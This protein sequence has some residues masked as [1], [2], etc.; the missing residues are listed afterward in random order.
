MDL[1]D[2]TYDQFADQYSSMIARQDESACSFY[3]DLVVPRLLDYI[4]DVADLTVLDAG[5][6]EG[7]VSRIL[8]NHG[9]QVVALDISPRLIELAR[10]NNPK[11]VMDYQVHDLSKPLPQYTQFF[12]L[13]VSNLVLNDVYDYR[14]FASTLGAVTKVGGRLVLS[15]NN[16][17]SAVMREK[18]TNYF[19]S[20]VSIQY[21]GLASVGV[22]VYFFHRTLEEYI[23]AFR[24]AG[25]LLRSLSDVGPKEEM[26]RSDSPIAQKY[27]HFPF[28]MILEFI[29][30]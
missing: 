30:Q 18:V 14:S 21:Q 4:G 25:F 24:D 29:K 11:A 13:V 28:F 6:G 5:C 2:N 16:P 20:G 9:A 1:R 3:H 22:K 10:A 12:D 7:Y 23:T 17:Y 8:A 15:M 27:H 26:M 19:D